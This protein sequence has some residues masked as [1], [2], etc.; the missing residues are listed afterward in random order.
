MDWGSL[1]ER[2]RT[3]FKKYRFVIL[4]L[5]AGLVLMLLPETTETAPKEASQEESLQAESLEESLGHIL[6]SIE[7]AGK[8]SVLLTE[9]QGR[10]VLYQVDED[11]VTGEKTQDIRR[12]TVVTT[13]TARQ[14]TGLIRQ[15]NPPVL[16]GAV[17]VCQGA[18]RPKVKLAI[19]EAVMRATGL[20]SNCICVLKM[21]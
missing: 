1:I 3:Y 7:G 15:V 5:A 12:K 19:M 2:A 14:E 17:V 9:K 21:K 11:T 8:V 20:P 10:E 4:V 6:S 18:D 16:Q 13:D